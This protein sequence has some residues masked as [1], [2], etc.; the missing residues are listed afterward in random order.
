LLSVVELLK[1]LSVVEGNG[2]HDPVMI[3]LR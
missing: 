3:F 1:V 2:R